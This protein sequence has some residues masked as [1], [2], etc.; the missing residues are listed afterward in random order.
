[1]IR[2]KVTLVFGI[3]LLIASLLT[4]YA[5]LSDLI[6]GPLYNGFFGSARGALGV[7]IEQPPS[8]YFYSLAVAYTIISL[9]A[10]VSGIGLLML[11]KWSR[12]L[13]FFLSGLGISIAVINLIF[14]TVLNLYFQFIN[15]LFGFFITILFYSL[16][17]YFLARKDIKKLFY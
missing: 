8:W 10:F 16:L 6:N 3:I 9:V 5:S 15:S 17:I 13:C 11:K 12:N 14:L 7:L 2:S 4:G 1:M